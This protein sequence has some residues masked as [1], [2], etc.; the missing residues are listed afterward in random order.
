M[1]GRTTCYHHGGTTPTGYGL[2]QTTH[3]R[4]SKLL[5]LRLAQTYEAARTN[6]EL[7]SVRDDIAVCESRLMDLFSRVDSGESGQRWQAMCSTLD[8]FVAAL[9]V[10]D[11]QAM[12]A[13]LQTMRQLTTQGREDHVAWR[14]IQ[15]LWETRCKLTQTESK[16]LVA[17]QQ[18]VSTEK[19]MVYFGVITDVIQRTVQEHAEAPVARAILG[20]L[21]TEF[22]R[23]G[24]YESGAEA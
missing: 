13:Q 9:A 12:N 1:H 17:M 7:L 18:M 8:T 6:K 16:R 19:L 21:S 24:L 3:G 22:G 11:A 23:I 10:K 4:Y 5:P 20:A 14:E 15:S 2:P